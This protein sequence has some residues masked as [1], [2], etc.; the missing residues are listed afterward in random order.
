[1]EP[2]AAGGRCSEAPLVQ[3]SKAVEEMREP[4]DRFGHRKLWVEDLKIPPSPP[5]KG[6][7]KDIATEKL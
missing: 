7:K 2:S 6:Y 3:R 5:S 1:M 4:D